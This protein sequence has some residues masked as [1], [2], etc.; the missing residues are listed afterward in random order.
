MEADFDAVDADGGVEAVLEDG[1]APGPL[2]SFVE[3]VAEPTFPVEEFDDVVV[4]AEIQEDGA[5]DGLFDGGAVGNDARVVI[6]DVGDAVVD[7]AVENYR[8]ELL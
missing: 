5:V 6:L 4:V 3:L 7:E 2:F 1:F 8:F